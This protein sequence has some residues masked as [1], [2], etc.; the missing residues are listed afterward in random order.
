M[1]H[2]G[3]GRTPSVALTSACDYFVLY[4]SLFVLFHVAASLHV[5]LGCITRLSTMQ[6]WSMDGSPI[7][8]SRFNTMQDVIELCSSPVGIMPSR[9]AIPAVRREFPSS[10]ACAW[11]DSLHQLACICNNCPSR[12][13]DTGLQMLCCQSRCTQSQFARCMLYGCGAVRCTLSGQECCCG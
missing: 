9:P 13:M 10:S 6:A 2:T 12:G 7:S 1:Y 8:C 3:W 4:W 5:V 11:V